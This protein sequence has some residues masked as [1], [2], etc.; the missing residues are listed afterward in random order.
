MRF[1]YVALATVVLLGG[2]SSSESDTPAT[3]SPPNEVATT[4]PITTTT[5]PTT[6]TA[7]TTT[8]T[9]TTT[10]LLGY[11]PAVAVEYEVAEGW[12]YTVSVFPKA[13]DPGSSPGGCIDPAPPG[14]TNIVFRMEIENMLADRESPSP[15]IV[16]GSNIGNDSD[17]LTGVD[18]FPDGDAESNW[19]ILEE[20]VPN[21]PDTKCISAGA[22]YDTAGNIPAGGSSTHLLTI[23]PVNEEGL[24]DVVVGLRLFTEIGKFIQA[25][26]T[27]MPDSG[28]VSEIQ[29][30][31]FATDD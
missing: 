16:A 22:I 29:S 18:P 11:V 1:V 28:V 7:A 12:R 31:I 9:S 4:T 23:G 5:T 30:T 25:N 27:L 10:T 15:W 21:G 3:T 24:P 6:T 8:S 26:F 19:K 20:I 2:C 13:P 17:V 14:Q